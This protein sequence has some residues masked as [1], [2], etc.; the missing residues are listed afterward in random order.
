V[1]NLGLLYTVRVIPGY[2]A[3]A[4]GSS[5]ADRTLW[6]QT[7]VLEHAL[8]S[9]STSRLATLDPFVGAR[10]SWRRLGR[11]DQR[12]ELALHVGVHLD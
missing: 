3:P 10:Y 8:L 9:Q 5:A 2:L 1:V 11:A 7:V 6:E 12:R 4:A